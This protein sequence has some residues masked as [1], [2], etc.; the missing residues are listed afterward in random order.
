MIEI[1]LLPGT[2][3]KSRG[4]QASSANFGAMFQGFAARVRD[5]FLIG[6]VAA[7]ILSV[8]VV[9]TLWGWQQKRSSDLA[10]REQRAVQDS[11]RYA[12]A[13]LER[14]GAQMKRDS[15]LR[16]INVIKSIDNN[17]FV[18]PHL[19]DEVSRALPPYT[20]LKSVQ[21][22]SPMA[23]PA[24]NRDTSSK[25]AD[26]AAVPMDTVKFRIT[27]NTVDIQALT[28]YMRMLEAS[29]FIQ[30]VQLVSTTAA[31]EDQKEV[32]QFQ[33]TGEFQQPDSSAIRTVPV[34]LTAR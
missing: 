33:L 25:N 3:K 11:V 24:A 20:W 23:A 34:V 12:A 10:E 1:N 7:V 13:L 5:P 6:A 8:L 15:V 18:W 32:T 21:Q 26:A 28:R 29:P 22:T 31:L 2:G 9:G 14:R 17:R 27:G 19:L 4:R 16:Q 30:N